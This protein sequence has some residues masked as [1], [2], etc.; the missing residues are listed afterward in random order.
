MFLNGIGKVK[1]AATTLWPLLSAHYN[2]PGNDKLTL[3][4]AESKFLNELNKRSGSSSGYAYQPIPESVLKQVDVLV[5]K[6]KESLGQIRQALYRKSA[7]I[8]L[9]FQRGLQ[10]C[11][12]IWRE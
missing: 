6:H 7:S 8:R 5:Q 10:L 3:S 2:D 4:D 1:T 9:T 12:L 11:C